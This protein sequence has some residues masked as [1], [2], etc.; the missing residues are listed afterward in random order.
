MGS[1]CLLGA[2]LV[3]SLSAASQAA[4]AAPPASP[5]EPFFTD[6]KAGYHLRSFYMDKTNT[7]A[8]VNQAW[9]AGGWLYA[10][11]GYWKDVL[12]LGAT[13]YFSLPIYAPDGEGGTQLLRPPQE[14]IGVLGELYARARYA[15]QT[16]T[17]Y[18]Q[19][20]NMGY[21]PPSGVRSNRSDL[22][23]VGRLDN[24]MVPVTY[25]AAL[26]GGPIALPAR[27]DQT[28]RY[29]AGYAWDAK[30]R[31]ANE[32]VSM[33]EAVGA[34]DSAAGMSIAG[35]QWSP[36]EDLW[37]QAW[38]HRAND[39]LGIVFLDLDYVHRL[40]R[41]SYWRFGTQYTHQDSAGGSALAGSSFSTWN[42]QAYAEFGWQRLKLYG[43]YSTIADAQQ[44]R[45]PFS[46]GPIYTQMVT[47]NFLRAGEATAM[48]GA[49]FGLDE[50][51]PG[52]SLWFEA[53][54][55]RH[56]VVAGGGSTLPNEREYDIGTSWTFREKGS[57]FDGARIR[58]RAAWVFDDDP[59]GAQ[60]GSDY[61]VDVNWPI[62]FL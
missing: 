14:P 3:L 61:R 27:G 44:I 46:S 9:A 18:R 1:H 34:K 60:R 48:L 7:D 41:Q 12:Q 29:W 33:G 31:D 58:A 50:I 5:A 37:M 20:I 43:A 21:A 30:P 40:Q 19:E 56:A 42:W 52:L 45:T 55:G 23:Y 22:A 11:S 26:L 54:D 4:S 57:I 62:P 13:F 2:V 24:R 39:V 16:L 51:L 47:R 49:S 28:L 6:A 38:Y 10:R 25:Q 8:S 36:V 59:G 35:V 17:L 32:F 53:A 15:S